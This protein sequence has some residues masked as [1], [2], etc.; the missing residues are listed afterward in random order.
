MEGL[1]ERVGFVAIGAYGGNQGELFY[2]AGYPVVFINTAQQDLDSLTDIPDSEKYHIPGGEGCSKDRSKSKAIFS[3]DLDNVVN[4]IKEKLVGKDYIFIIG[5]CGGGTASGILASMKR[6]IIS[7]LEPK[8]CMIVT[9]LPNTRTESLK[10]MENAYNTLCEIEQLD[11]DGATFILDNDRLGDK[12]KINEQF[13]IYLDALLT[14]HSVSKYGNADIEEIKKMLETPGMSVLT[15]LDKD[16]T[17][18]QQIINSFQSNIYAPM[19]EDKVITYLLIISA[20]LGA[21]INTEEINAEFGKPYDCFR[22]YEADST[23]CMLSGLSL[24]Y[25]KLEEIQAQLEES[26]ETIKHNRA[27]KREKRLTN[28]FEFFD[29]ADDKEEK[30][31]TV[32]KKNTR[33]LLFLN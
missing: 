26:K 17:N 19:E 27:V 10:A 5:S 31:K 33:D 4:V 6:I 28:K 14:N 22:G 2:K 20:G 32:K 3:A 16:K 12:L 29:S 25:T 15:Q 11:E 30:P 9:V 1:K 7:E 21:S 13:F 23:I 24:P 18:T 8:A